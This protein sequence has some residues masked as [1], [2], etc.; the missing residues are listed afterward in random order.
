MGYRRGAGRGEGKRAV[1]DLFPVLQEQGVRCRSVDDVDR[2]LAKAAREWMRRRSEAPSDAGVDARGCLVVVS[3]DGDFAPLLREARAQRILAVSVTPH[4]ATQTRKLV[5]A[6]DLV[7]TLDVAEQRYVPAAQTD[8]GRRLLS[9]L[10][11]RLGRK[12][13]A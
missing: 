13:A 9:A 8:A 4:S 1:N 6:A 10:E 3:E 11:D 5:A 7:A 12:P 2:S